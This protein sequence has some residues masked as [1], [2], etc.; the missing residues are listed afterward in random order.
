VVL[1][2]PWPQNHRPRTTRKGPRVDEG[3]EVTNTEMMFF[4]IGF[5]LMV[6]ILEKR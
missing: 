5:M 4:G 6:L 2:L 3:A 1:A